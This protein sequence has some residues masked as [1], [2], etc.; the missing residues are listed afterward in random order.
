MT[1]VAGRVA[2]R[3]G[4][5]GDQETLWLLYAAAPKRGVARCD[6]R[7]TGKGYELVVTGL[8]AALRL[9]YRSERDAH[10]GSL[11]LRERLLGS[12]WSTRRTSS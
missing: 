6:L 2:I 11:R 8:G 9:S 12:G 1:A 4:P 5:D 7:V 10:K 3:R